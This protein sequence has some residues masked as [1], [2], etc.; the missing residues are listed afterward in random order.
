MILVVQAARGG[1]VGCAGT[2]GFGY[3]GGGVT[4]PPFI[5]PHPAQPPHGARAP[6]PPSAQ[7][8]TICRSRLQVERA[9]YGCWLAIDHGS[10]PSL[11]VQPRSCLVSSFPVTVVNS[12]PKI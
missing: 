4:R 1:D 9:R 2:C 7:L 5:P 10:C 11:A 8:P 12:G 6:P 3:V